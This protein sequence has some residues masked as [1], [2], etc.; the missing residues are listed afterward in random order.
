VT[1]IDGYILLETNHLPQPDAAA[2]TPYRP[3]YADDI[4]IKIGLS[5]L[6]A[7]PLPPHKIPPHRWI[8]IG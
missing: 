3:A 5:P 6:H 4:Y 2:T 7:A 1:K 8:R